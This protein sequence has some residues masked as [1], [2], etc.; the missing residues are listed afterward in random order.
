MIIIGG[1]IIGLATA[2]SIMRA[3]PSTRL[4][5]IEKEN[6][7]AKHQS[8][9][10]SG[11]IHSGIYYVPGS[12]KAKNCISGY[13]E[14]LHFCR[15]YS[16]PYEI[17]GK[18]IVATENCELKRLEDIH[19]RG[20]ANGLR[21]LRFLSPEEIVEI[22]PHC[23]GRRGL[24]VPQTGIIDYR[25]VSKKYLELL[26][27]M[28]VN[29]VF[30]E[31]VLDLKR[32][33]GKIEVIGSSKTWVDNFVISCAGLYSDRL[34][35]KTEP[36]LPIRILPFRGEY[37]RFKESA[38]KLVNNLIYPVPNP[39]F[40]FL[41]VHFTRMINGNIECGPN[42]VFALSREGYAKTDIN[43]YDIWDA[44]NWP[45]FR[46]ISKKYWRF[47]I[48]EYYRSISK[49]Q[50]V[51]QLKRLLPSLEDSFIEPY[52]SGVR[53]QACDING[54]LLDDFNIRY[55]DNIIHICNAP[56]PAAT[57]S[58]AIGNYVAKYAIKNFR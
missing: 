2:L 56:S 50:F 35:L 19:Q 20:L 11:V 58:L 23:Q 51:K 14:M 24:L 9:N 37:Y 27:D 32:V 12:L 54:N 30:N 46:K 39:N 40:P 41:G 26:M 16:I 57:A 42:A 48:A 7:V 10:N 52:G 44:L 13:S 47:A 38:P 4:T 28:G 6:T 5:L 53:A 43:F 22:E 25:A 55:D 3:R 31:K 8:G 15:Q 36:D 21:G 1:G 17:C 34:A 29:V 33:N 49:A 45:G 18:I